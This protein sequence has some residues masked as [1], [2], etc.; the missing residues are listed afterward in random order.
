MQRVTAWPRSI[1]EWFDERIDLDPLVHA[2]LDVEI[3]RGV[4]TY[5][6]GGLTFFFFFVQTVTGILLVIYYQPSP[7]GAYDS[8]LFIM[9]EVRF[10][11]L[12]RSVHFWGAHLMIITA[13]LHL[14]RIFLQGSYKPPRELTWVVGVLLLLISLAF[15]LTGY[16]LP[17][18]QRAFWATTVTTEIAGAFPLVGEWALE[19]LRGGSQVANLTLSRFF[20]THVLVL[21][22]ALLGLLFIHLLLVHEQGLA[23]PWWV[24]REPAGDDTGAKRP[25]RLLPFFPNYLVDE[26]I[27][28]YFGLGV[29]IVLASLFPAGLEEQADPFQT[30]GDV[31]P[32]WYFLFLYQGLK[33][34]PRIIGVTAPVLGVLLLLAVPFLDRSPENHPRRRILALGVGIAALAGILGLSAWGWIS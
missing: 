31:K 2:L 27:A 11:W 8:V 18:D 3:P 12:I 14:L 32:E 24:R 5:Y 4:R 30:P 23:R 25:K 6:L 34:V 29:L 19:F 1:R 28:W 33:I 9:N 26:V 21:P 15:G 20:G 17:W 13:V 7:Q 16:L 10:G 22:A